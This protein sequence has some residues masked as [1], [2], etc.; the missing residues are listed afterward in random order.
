M[1]NVIGMVMDMG[2]F[3][4]VVETRGPLLWP[5]IAVPNVLLCDYGRSE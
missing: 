3:V 2:M 4:V 1:V 5:I